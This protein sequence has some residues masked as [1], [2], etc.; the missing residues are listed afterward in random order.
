MLQTC[1]GAFSFIHCFV[2]K[3]RIMF[4][5]LSAQNNNLKNKCYIWIISICTKLNFK[6]I[7]VVWKSIYFGLVTN[8]TGGR[9]FIF[10]T[11]QAAVLPGSDAGSDSVELA[12]GFFI[13]NVRFR[14][15]CGA[16]CIG[17]RIFFLSWREEV[18]CDLFKISALAIW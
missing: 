10:L 11:P 1:I 16:Q 4:Q 2:Q 15:L 8:R 9:G 12:S 13:K 17:N 3:V 14:A 18:V 7:V 5:F 6:L